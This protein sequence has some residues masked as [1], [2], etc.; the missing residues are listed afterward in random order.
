[1]IL[2]EASK[3]L[4]KKI[5]PGRVQQAEQVALM[6]LHL[7]FTGE[8]HK[9]FG[10]AAREIQ[11]AV[12]ET[13]GRDGTLDAM[14]ALRIQGNATEI[15]RD[16]MTRWVTAFQQARA[17]SAGLAF[18]G[19]AVQVEEV[20]NLLADPLPKGSLSEG[21]TA[22]VFDPQVQAILQAGA[23]HI[24]ADGMNLSARIWN[25]EQM[26]LDSINREVMGALQRGN[27][28]WELAKRLEG[29]LGAGKGCP[30]WT[31]DRLY[32]LTKTDIA[33]GNLTGLLSGG[34]CAGQ[35]VSYNALRMARNEIQTAHQAATDQVFA[36]IPWI[37]EERIVLS[38]SHPKLACEC[39]RVTSG[40]RDGQGIY[41][42]GEIRLP[43]HPQC[44]CQKLGVQ[45]PAEEFTKN[46]RGWMR[47]EQTWPAMDQFHEQTRGVSIN[48]PVATLL[49][50]WVFGGRDALLGSLG[51]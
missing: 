25:L 7:F 19:L 24:Y 22:G 4:V 48:D 34:E 49:G 14:A 23:T 1:M 2:D 39:E 45:P 35:G 47:G 46:L 16:A 38:K 3:K 8:S 42:K 21:I 9:L 29:Q 26:S 12:L 37:E 18:G 28:A 40:G 20:R 15:F 32:G 31:E 30:R 5:E 6:R 43:L 10:Q 44:L 33:T 50:V 27:S 51:L 11:S 41:P 13:G 36:Q 17:I